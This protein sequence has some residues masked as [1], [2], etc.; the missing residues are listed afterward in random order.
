[1]CETKQVELLLLTALIMLMLTCSATED[2]RAYSSS[3]VML[4]TVHFAKRHCGYHE[5]K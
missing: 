5:T 3:L 2:S 4:V 1:M